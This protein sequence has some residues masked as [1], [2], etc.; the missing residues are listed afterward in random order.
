VTAGLPA[1]LYEKPLPPRAPK[2]I[3]GEVEAHL[4]ALAWSA[5]P[6]GQQRWPLRL[7]ADRLVELG[8]VDSLRHVAVY[9]RSYDAKRPQVCLDEARKELH[10]P[11]RARSPVSPGG[12]P[13]KI[14]RTSAMAPPA[15]FCGW[16]PSPGGGKS[17]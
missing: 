17:G 10:S 13:G 14:M 6:E 9:Q 8:L 7:L 2:K 16:S 4:I 5:P 11:P 1:A 15:S 12:Q 3:T